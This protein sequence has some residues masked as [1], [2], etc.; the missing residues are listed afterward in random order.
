MLDLHVAGRLPRRGLVRQ[1]QVRFEEF[2]PTASASTTNRRWRRG[3]A[4]AWWAKRTRARC[5][6]AEHA[7]ELDGAVIEALKQLGVSAAA[8]IGV[9]GEW[10]AG[11]RRDADRPLADRRQHAGRVCRGDAAAGGRRD[12]RGG[13]RRFPTW[14]D[15][16]APVRGEFVRRIGN[17]FREHKAELATLVTLGSRQDHGRSAA[18]KCRR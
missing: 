7:A 8:A 11:E 3:S 4:A 1:E 12:R 2:L 17:A 14:R 13:R 6:A 9:G 10:Q 15:T 18:A 16:P 5:I